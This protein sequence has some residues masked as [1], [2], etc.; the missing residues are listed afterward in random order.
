MKRKAIIVDL[1][2]TLCHNKEREA[3]FAEQFAMGKTF[4]E[5]NKDEMLKK[6]RETIPSDEQNSV[7]AML[8]NNKAP[9]IEDEMIIVLYVTA[10]SEAL[11][12]VTLEWLG[13]QPE[14]GWSHCLFMRELFDNRPDWEVKKDIYQTLIAD[15]YDVLLCLEDRPEVAAMW[16]SLG[17]QC[18]QVA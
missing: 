14:L 8:L 17:L 13:N 1:D 5:I 15:K 3:W 16:R 12:G 9:E 10:R 11:F 7:I 6:L 4:E 18:W 2:G